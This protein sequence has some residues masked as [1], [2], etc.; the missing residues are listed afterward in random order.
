MPLDPM[1]LRSAV[2]RQGG[3][4]TVEPPGAAHGMRYALS[5]PLRAVALAGPGPALPQP[6]PGPLPLAGLR[7]LLVDDLA[8]A[9][10]MLAALLR[11]E[12]AQVQACASGAQALAWLD[13]QS[14]APWP[15]LLV[16]DILLGEEDGYAVMRAV[17]AR[18]D[19]R[20]VALAERM[21]AVALTG[22]AQPGDRVRALMAGFQAHLVKPVAP[23]ELVA[24][25][26]A[27]AARPPAA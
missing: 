12:G 19:A 9:R 22:L 3:Q 15:Q 17:R 23:Q 13:A 24:T 14:S 27:L 20:N 21:S 10:E 11:R 8:D 26:A 6:A 7:I 2:E 16:C 1:A 25:L 5:L 4:F 18:E